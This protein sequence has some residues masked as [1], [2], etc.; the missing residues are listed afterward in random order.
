[1]H[2][3]LLVL[4][5]LLI[6][7]L[8]LLAC[9]EEEDN[10]GETPSADASALPY[11]PEAAEPAV[12]PAVEGTTP[13][14]IIE[15]GEGPEGVA[16]DPQTGLVAVGTREP[17]ELVLVNGVSGEI[18]ER[19]RIPSAPRHLALAEPGGPVLVPAEDANTL[20]EVSLPDGETRMTEVGEN[21]HDVA[22]LDD[23]IYVGDE[24]S[25]TL[26][27]VE[28]GRLVRQ[29]PVDVQPG[30]VIE[31]DDEIGIVS[32][33]A[34]TLELFSLEE[35]LQAQG[36]QNAGL[37]P[38]HVVR[39]DEGRLFVTDTRGDAVLVYETQPRLKFVG[40]LELPGS[41]YGIAIDRERG[42][43]WVTL[44]GRNEV[45]ELNAADVPQVL[46]RFPTVRQPN[47][48]AVTPGGG[49]LFIAS[50]TDGTLQLLDPG[51]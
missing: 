8:A 39:D 19:V 26:S 20:V 22:F 12:S 5:A 21:P 35:D 49:R 47:T 42:R 40:R 3:V 34:Y 2:R 17:G 51:G 9:G 15:V 44:T 31:L 48:L 23:R 6:L 16:F 30:G 37:G 36:S 24:F 13:G 33:R 43:V 28:D 50:R 41:P 4:A 45:V 11:P 18:T 10:G 7:P 27:V 1:M 29:V 32:V 46:R 14:E 25:S 38:T